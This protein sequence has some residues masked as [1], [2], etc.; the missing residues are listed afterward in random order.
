MTWPVHDLEFRFKM[1]LLLR[2]AWAQPAPCLSLT[3]LPCIFNE[4]TARLLSYNFCSKRV[5]VGG[6]HQFPFHLFDTIPYAVRTYSLKLARWDGNQS[7]DL[8]I[9]AFHSITD[10]CLFWN[11]FVSVIF[12]QSFPRLRV[13][14]SWILL[15]VKLAATKTFSIYCTHL[16]SFW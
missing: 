10:I 12:S 3:S 16:F 5:Y 11:G 9:A 14:L 13:L 2:P 7:I 4:L 15:F 1:F 6:T 8:P